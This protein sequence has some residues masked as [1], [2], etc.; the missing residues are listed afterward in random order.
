MFD[1]LPSAMP[2]IK[3]GRLRALAITTASRYPA[4]PDLPTLQESGVAGYDSS[5]WFG[6]VAPKGTPPEFVERI[7]AE[8][9]KILAL[10]DV[11]EKLEAQGAIPAPGTPADFGNLIQTEVRK[12]AAVVRASG[13][14]VE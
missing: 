13:A 3:S 11:R 1:N 9:N 10:P 12:W 4:L 7:N 8:V 6:I 2:H 14:R 5:A